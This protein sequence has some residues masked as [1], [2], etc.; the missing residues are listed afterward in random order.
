MA[1]APVP[2]AVP[3]QRV[4]PISTRRELTTSRAEGMVQTRLAAQTVSP[5][6][7]KRETRRW[8]VGWEYLPSAQREL[9]ELAWISTQGGAQPTFWAPP[10]ESPLLVHILEW[11]S[12][13]SGPL[14]A[15]R[16]MLEEAI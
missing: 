11:E 3:A 5:T 16:A 7:G 1:S 4:D 14:W 15:I 12:G 9:L 8:L 13:A 2:I 10:G 6:S